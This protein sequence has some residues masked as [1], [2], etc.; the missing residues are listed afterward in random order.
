MFLNVKARRRLIKAL[1]TYKHFVI[2]VY[3]RNS[4]MPKMLIMRNDLIIN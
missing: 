4:N 3:E 1:L 2:N